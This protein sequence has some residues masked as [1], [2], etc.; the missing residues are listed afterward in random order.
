M[1]S[2]FDELRFAFQRRDNGLMKII[3]INIAVYLT[4]TVLSV[5]L[6]LS[7]AGQVYDFLA[8][9]LFL[10][11]SVSG[12]LAKPW[13]LITYF[14]AHEDIFHILFN[15]LVLYWFGRLVQEY[16]GNRKVV[17]LYFLGGIA[18]GLF[19]ILLYNLSPYFQRVVG[20]SVL[21]GASAG[22]YAVVVG[23]ATFIP[24]Y[25]FFML[26]LGP[27]RII[28]IAAFYVVLSLAESVGNNA[29]GALA[30]LGGAL[31]GYL[32]ISQLKQGRDWS[33]SFYRVIDWFGSAF[34]P[35]PKIKVSYRKQ[36]SSNKA[37]A[38]SSS[39]PRRGTSEIDQEEIDK[40]L[41]KIS[42]RGY[43]ALSKE[44][45]QKLF[46]ASKKP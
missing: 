30:H 26:F 41:D 4:L 35:K 18:G 25:T 27:V 34:Q 10:P 45:K 28:Y 17:T 29:G 39:A 8:E 12:F 43:E 21:L 38:G 14:F 20:S 23:A 16:L 7:G 46:N 3:F 15:L 19:Y 32:V 5:V 24:N 11:A 13:T 33:A 37:T 31:M 2:F 6:R 44:E 1:N 42:E 22:V 36:G 40:I 9:Q